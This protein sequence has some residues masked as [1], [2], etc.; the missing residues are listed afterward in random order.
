MAI[1]KLKN[2][3]LR[4]KLK[5]KHLKKSISKVEEPTQSTKRKESM[6]PDLFKSK[7][8]TNSSKQHV[9]QATISRKLRLTKPTENS[10][11]NKRQ[12]EKD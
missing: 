9:H 6:K 3:Y 5:E 11:E 4:D 2:N 7:E 1:G 8:K 10:I 12:N